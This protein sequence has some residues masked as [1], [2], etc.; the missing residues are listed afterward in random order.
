MKR[1]LL[2]GL[3]PV[4][5]LLGCNRNQDDPKVNPII[6]AILAIIPQKLS[7]T[8][9][10]LADRPKFGDVTTIR[11]A[12]YG[13]HPKRTDRL[14]LQSI[15]L[16][17]RLSTEYI[18]DAQGR[19]IEKKIYYNDGHIYESTRF[20]YPPTGT[21][22]VEY[23]PNKNAVSG[24]G[25]PP[26]DD[27]ILHAFT[28]FTN[29]SSDAE[30]V[31][32]TQRVPNNSNTNYPQEYRYGF[33]SLGQLVWVEQ[34]NPYGLSGDYSLYIR[35]SQGNAI[36]TKYVRLVQS[37]QNHT[38]M[39]KY[40]QQKNPYY[41]TGDLTDDRATNANNILLE[42]SSNSNSWKTSYSYQYRADGYPGKVTYPHAQLGTVTLE[43]IYDR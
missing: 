10:S 28:T 43:F 40:D 12:P 27:L 36:Q 5:L 19:L 15:L 34:P 14:R 41:T 26:N 11:Q 31:K 29:T 20:S 25:Y 4:M 38:T 17:G 9:P 22:R 35:D 6:P 39:Y 7:A 3:I 13:L 33:N 18:Y 8:D 30:L 21:I 1:A 2:T 37:D 24:G 42:E 32:T 16:N 23:W